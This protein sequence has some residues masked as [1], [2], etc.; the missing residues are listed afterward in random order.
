MDIGNQVNKHAKQNGDFNCIIKEKLNACAGFAFKVKPGSGSSAAYHCI[1][2][3]HAHHLI[4]KKVPENFEHLQEI[5]PFYLYIAIY[6]CNDCYL[7]RL[8]PGGLSFIAA[9]RDTVCYRCN[10][11]QQFLCTFNPFRIEGI[12]R[13]FSLFAP[14]NYFCIA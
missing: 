12:V 2:P 5:P 6:R 13:P 3:F 8:I 4:L 7:S 9:T 10:L 11:I 1:Q 14:Y